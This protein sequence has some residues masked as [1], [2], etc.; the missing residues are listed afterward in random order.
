[1]LARAINLMVAGWRSS[2]LPAWESIV[3]IYHTPCSLAP[4]MTPLLAFGARARNAY[5]ISDILCL[6]FVTTCVRYD[7]VGMTKCERK[8]SEIS[9][10]DL[11][12]SRSHFVP[13]DILRSGHRTRRAH[14]LALSAVAICSALALR[15]WPWR[16]R[17]SLSAGL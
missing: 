13:Y 15:A 2:S 11:F 10:I 14:A 1:M 4:H 17:M 5:D 16:L 7:K 3:F 12:I 6:H 9:D 8:I